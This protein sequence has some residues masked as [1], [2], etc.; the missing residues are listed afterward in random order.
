[1][2]RVNGTRPPIFHL[3]VS[4]EGSKGVVDGC[5]SL[6]CALVFVGSEFGGLHWTVSWLAETGRSSPQKR[7]LHASRKVSR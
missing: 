5:R 1:M 4:P 2:D 6:G 7:V 3:I